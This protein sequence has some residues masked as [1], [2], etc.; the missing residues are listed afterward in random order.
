MIGLSVVT[1]LAL[2]FAVLAQDLGEVTL[3]VDPA[4]AAEVGL[5]AWIWKAWGVVRE[6]QHQS[7]L[8][9]AYAIVQLLVLFMRTSLSNRLGIVKLTVISALNVAVGVLS[10][11]L[12]GQDWLSALTGAAQMASISVFLHQVKA[13]VSRMP[14]E[15]EAKKAEQE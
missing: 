12:A 2:S 15:L 8:A 10:A 13:Q 4:G 3:A 5:I 1:G 6:I 14:S 7:P 11:K 9:A